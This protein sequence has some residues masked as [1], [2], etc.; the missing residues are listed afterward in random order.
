M[1]TSTLIAETFGGALLALGGMFI[2]ELCKRCKKARK[3][4]HAE[5]L[6]RSTIS[7][8]SMEGL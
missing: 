4:R 6:A 7:K 8:T 2:V 5:R 3:E 1:I